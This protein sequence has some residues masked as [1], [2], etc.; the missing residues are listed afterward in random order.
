MAS[1][2]ERPQES[3]PQESRPQE[4]CPQES[5]ELRRVI[6]SFDLLVKGHATLLRL[7]GPGTAAPTETAIDL[8]VSSLLD[9]RYT[10]NHVA[11]LAQALTCA[12]G[13]ESPARARSSSEPASGGPGDAV[14]TAG[15]SQDPRTAPVGRSPTPGVTSDVQPGCTALV[16]AASNGNA[17]VQRQGSPWGLWDGRE[18]DGGTGDVD[19]GDQHLVDELLRAQS[20]CHSHLT[21]VRPCTAVPM[22]WSPPHTH[23]LSVLESESDQI[24]RLHTP[25]KSN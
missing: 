10:P 15:S 1:P 16:V 19:P 22:N 11:E 20:L 17:E 5:D 13:L 4:S 14:G 18:F 12:C 23:R 8:A 6:Q 21:L 7:F 9:G 2:K 24:T 25:S 3:H